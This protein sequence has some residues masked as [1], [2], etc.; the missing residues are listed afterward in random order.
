MDAKTKKKNINEELDI[1]PRESEGQPTT[2]QP[3][4]RQSPTG[5]ADQSVSLKARQIDTMHV[6][7]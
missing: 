7:V 2:L 1:I 4:I 6:L 5:S 3:G